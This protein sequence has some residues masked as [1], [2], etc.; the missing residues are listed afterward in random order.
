MG[1]DVGLH[2]GTQEP[3]Q[4]H[5]KESRDEVQEKKLLFLSGVVRDKNNVLCQGQGE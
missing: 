3:V 2:A 1:L 4:V 5:T